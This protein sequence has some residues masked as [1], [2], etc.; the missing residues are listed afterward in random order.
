MRKRLKLERA[1]TDIPKPTDMKATVTNN[2]LSWIRYWVHL[3]HHRRR[4][5]Q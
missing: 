3:S 2:V 5:R 1:A 4:I